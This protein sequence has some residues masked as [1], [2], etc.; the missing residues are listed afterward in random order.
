MPIVQIH[1]LPPHDRSRL[2]RMLTDVREEGARAL[3]GAPSNVWVMF[4]ELPPGTY[5]Q[6][7]G[8]AASE[9][10]AST[11]PPVIL[12]SIQSGRSA[13]QKTAFTRAVAGVVARTLEIPADNVWVHWR[14]MRPEDVW[15]GSRWSK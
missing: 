6:G 5:L 12:I 1:S 9:P 3:A 11:H 4:H 15:F 14:E 8:E 10:Q 7:E 2:A 13:E